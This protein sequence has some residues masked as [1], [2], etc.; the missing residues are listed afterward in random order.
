[1]R[2]SHGL[3]RLLA[4]SVRDEQIESGVQ[5]VESMFIRLPQ[6]ERLGLGYRPPPVAQMSRQATPASL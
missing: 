5:V 4:K 3:R 2:V 6:L 1:M